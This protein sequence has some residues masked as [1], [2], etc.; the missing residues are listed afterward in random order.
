MTSVCVGLRSSLAAAI[1]VVWGAAACAGDGS[2]EVSIGDNHLRVDALAPDLVR[3]RLARQGMWAEDA[4]WSVPADVRSTRAPTQDVSDAGSA[5]LRTATLTVRV[6]RASLAVRIENATGQTV[7]SDAQVPVDPDRPGFILAKAMRH[8][9]HYFALG[10]KTGPLDRRGGRFA[11]WTTD[12][13]VMETADPLY[14][15]I[16]FLVVTGG[17]AGSWGLLVD[18]PWRSTFDLGHGQAGLLTID[19]EG[20]PLDYYVI[21]GTGVKQIVERYADLTGHPPM[22]PKWALG[23]QQSR[24]SYE[25]A[26]AVR[27]IASRLRHDRFPAD[28]IWLDIDF[29][30]R[31][32]PFTTNPKTFP[33]LP[34]LVAEL[35]AQGLQTVVISDL[36]IAKAPNQGYAPFDSGQ[37]ID[38]FVHN[39]DGTV[40]SGGVWPGPAVFPDF[41][42]ADVRTWWGGLYAGFIQAGVAGFW[43]DMNEPSVFDT[44][45]KTIPSDAVQRIATPGFAPRAASHA[46][47]HN[48]TGS[49]NAQATFEGLTRLRPDERPFVM[50]RSAYAG[51]QRWAV[52]WTGDNAS[53]WGQLKLGVAQTLNLGLS[54]FAYTAVD[55]GGFL[56]TP[57]PD[58]LTRWFEIQAF[59]PLFRDHTAKGTPPQEPWVHGPEHEAIR[60]HYVE[61]RYRLVPY[62]YALVDEAHRTGAPIVRPL[63]YD[64]PDMLRSPCDAALSFMLGSGLMIAGPPKPE[65]AAP[66]RVCLP[67]GRWFDYW[68]DR[69]VVPQGAEAATVPVRTTTETPRLDRLPV[70]V[71]AGTIL[72]RQALVRAL[73]EA[74]DGP[75]EL[76]VWP[77]DDCHG[78]LYDDDGHSMGF[79][80]GLFLRQRLRC[81]ETATGLSLDFAAREG[82]YQPPWRDVDVTVHGWFG[83]S[84]AVAGPDGGSLPVTVDR[85]RRTVRFTMPAPASALT[86]RLT[87]GS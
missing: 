27:A 41:T 85:D 73:S 25:S 78:I 50:T 33:D 53:T 81:A 39:R 70:Y 1:L 79:E 17:S 44:P 45:D 32:R 7:L 74:P 4:S 6:D 54:G 51:G 80:R 28:V 26:D 84:A 64:D 76:D 87:H 59:M 65:S 61:E 72:P 48:L 22:L 20:G 21:L 18:N 60:R 15:A 67:R 63:F 46:E 52:T 3:I 8:G 58:L 38:A 77:G 86:M 34:G 11:N 49:L 66:Y 68:T 42:R 83:A 14:K 10:D 30:D 37:A 69:E 55:V 40:F 43:N 36:H 19:A 13:T 47:V 62:L 56:G 57:T 2:L 16:P 29:Q 35:H 5:G 9:E 82:S 23:Y 31:N 24:Y 75:L 71:R 12:Q